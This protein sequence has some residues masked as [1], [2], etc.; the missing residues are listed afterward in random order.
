MNPLI[1]GPILEVGKTLLDAAYPVFMK[2]K[3]Q[4]EAQITAPEPAG[5]SD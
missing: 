5:L 1:L 4:A 2:V 3:A